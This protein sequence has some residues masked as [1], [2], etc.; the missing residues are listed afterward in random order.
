MK[1]WNK[2]ILRIFFCSLGWEFF[3]FCLVMELLSDL[4]SL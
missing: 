1:V 2:T 4:R 3:L